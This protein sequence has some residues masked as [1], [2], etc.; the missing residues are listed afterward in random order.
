MKLPEFLPAGQIC[1]HKTLILVSDSRERDLNR[2][3][4][5]GGSWD[6]GANAG[7]FT[8][9]LNN[10]PTNRNDNIG[11]RLSSDLNSEGNV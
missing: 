3:F 9:N 8:L 2:V 1:E 5:R 7:A 6:N 11:L 4:I 10:G